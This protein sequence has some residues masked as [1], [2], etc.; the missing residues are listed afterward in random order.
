MR[1]FESTMRRAALLA[2]CVALCVCNVLA[3]QT[4]GTLRGQI[5]DELGGVITGAS[6]TLVGSDASRKSA[7]TN[8]EGVF[9][10]SELAPGSYVL[11]AA[12]DGFA[13]YENAAVAVRAGRAET[14][15]IKLSVALKD[16]ET[17]VSAE[18]VG[19]GTDPAESA[20]SIVLRGRDLDSLSDDPDQLADD[21][22]TLAGGIDGPNGT[23]IFV[24][25]FSNTRL[26]PK[27]SILEVRINSNPFTAEQ[28]NL[29]FGRVEVITKAGADEFTGQAFFNFTDES[30]NA[31]NPYAPARGPYQTRLFGG[32][33]TG[34]IVSGKAAYFFDFERREIDENATVNATILDASGNV[35]PFSQ[36]ILTPQRRTTF[37]ARADYQLD[38]KNTLVARY[39]LLHTTAANAGV[40]GFSLASRA[41]DTSGTEHTLQLS[42]TMVV[43]ASTLNTT[44]FQFISS[45]REQTGDNS[46]PAV[47]VQDAFIGGGAQ[48]GLGFNDSDR[49]ELQNNTM[50]ASG[51]HVWNFGGRLRAVRISDASPSNFGGTYV[52]S[53]LEQYRQV[54]LGTP[55]ARPTQFTIAGGDPLASVTRFDFGGY[56]Q[57]DWR[58]RPNLT[59]S[60]GVRFESQSNTGD[61]IDIAPRLAFAWALGPATG[62]KRP[63][64]VIRGG[65]G[66]FYS[67][68]GEDLTLQANRFDGLNQ[69]RFIVADPDFYPRIPTAEELTLAAVPRTTLRVADDIESPYS[70]KGVISVERQLPLNNSTLSFV[71]IHERDRQLLR[72]RNINAPLHGTGLRPLGDTGNV[73]LFE[74][75]GKSVGNT[76]LVMF[77]GN[78]TRRLSVNAR[79]GAGSVKGDTEGAYYFPANSYDLSGEYG[80][81][82]YYSRH[83]G[84]VAMIYRA[85]WEL[86]FSPIIQA[87]TAEHFNITT[88]LDGNG[89]AVFTDR[90]AFATDLGR[91]SVVVTRFGA[92]DTNPLPGQ[93]IIPRNYGM[94]P[95]LV[96]ANLRV[97]KL[98]GIGTVG[99]AQPA[100]G[101][102]KATPPESRFFLMLTLQ[103]TNLFNST[104]QGPITGNL[105]SPLF[106]R[107]NTL[108]GTARRLEFQMRF[109]F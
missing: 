4:T 19:P 97:S 56:A 40:G 17:T 73:F 26:P 3:Q 55:G 9:V 92:F 101:K 93:T 70:M 105:S 20:G 77:R 47:I 59:L 100:D 61:K 87:R 64:T 44:R 81:Q 60:A 54:L 8:G 12:Q 5:K 76:L 106:G 104:N 52:F 15:D 102:G 27:S 78:V 25:G 31:R 85:P 71:F 103:A 66:I 63:K 41:F 95:G 65:A 49:F 74:S 32:N 1:L 86:T 53:S 88:G 72:S 23:Q 45:R 46:T 10:F 30:L 33:V 50:H 24:D 82:S 2:A 109:A 29:G 36:V 69:Q 68:V 16:E 57:D 79:Y 38:K 48:V 28:D 94:G 80:P 34:P 43:S 98:I 11:R 84:M 13:D 7:T 96:Q 108:G 58:V 75:G 107:S 18:G 51:A 89:D 6:V 14:V 67:R 99:G 39:N 83:A 91:P 37:S 22:R 35:E 62:G 42:D 21:L 90:P